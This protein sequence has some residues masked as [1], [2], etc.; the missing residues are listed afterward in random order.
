M[1]ELKN[2]YLAYNKE[3]YAL[4]DICMTFKPGDRIALVGEEG[5]G[6]TALL[7]L[8]AGLD[9]QQKGEVYIN[10]TPV[11][12]VNFARDVSL[13]YISSK[14]V[15]FE[16]KSVYRNLAWVL[17]NR[18]VDKSLWQ[19]QI[20][21]VLTDYG[22][23]H[24]RDAHVGTLCRSDRRLV[25]IAR[26]ALRPLD[27]LLCDDIEL[28]ADDKT[29]GKLGAALKKLIDSDNKDKI[30]IL[31]CNNPKGCKGLVDKKIKIQS[32]SIIAEV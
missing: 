9:A 25:Q 27:I 5:S 4:F 22:I 3:Y 11:K 15:F 7:R 24:L 12:K 6:K 21:K 29:Y 19:S 8:I 31:T 23:S 1:I 20:E 13:G 32:G 26:L 10:N 16:N 28:H 17:K 2:V 18:S 30:V 14:A